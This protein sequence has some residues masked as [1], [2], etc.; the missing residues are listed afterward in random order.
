MS[1]D[2][3]APL[4]RS[5]ERLAARCD[6]AA[7]R[8]DLLRQAQQMLAGRPG[9]DR[10]ARLDLAAK[11]ERWRYRQLQQNGPSAADTAEELVNILDLTA[12]ELAGRPRRTARHAQAAVAGSACCAAADRAAECLDP[13]IGL[14]EL[15]D[16]A[17]ELTA[18]HFTDPTTGRRRVLLYAPLYLSSHCVNY[19]EYCGFRYPNGIERRHLS[20][21]EAVEQAELLRSRGLKSI[22]L[23]AGDFPA[24]TT[25]EYYVQVIDSVVRCGLEPAVEI[26]PQPTGVYES[27][28][29][30]G[31]CGV[32]L[33]QET[34][35]RRLYALYHPRGSKAEYDWRLE[36][37]ERA[38]E[39][40]ISRLGLGILL[41]LADPR[42]DLLALIRHAE[43]LRERFP[44]CDLAV[45][46]PRIHTAPPSFEVPYRVDDEMLIRLYCALRI[47]LPEAELVLSTRESA[48]LRN[49]L[50]RICI[51]QLSAGSSTVPGGYNALGT[52]R[53]GEQ[54]PVSDH[55]DPAVVAAWLEAAGL[56]VQRRRQLG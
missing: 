47:A 17:A 25:G 37:P 20:P 13:E 8:L 39:G 11:L 28:A 14:G 46:L 38:A 53:G 2:L 3:D 45:S 56:Q 32:T 15:T 12:R 33:Y 48:A 44:E 54:F 16:R 42:D 10:T 26:A 21:A 30:A 1:I 18:R 31:A 50:T 34:Y 23:V 41:G 19:C 55:R 22:L 27:L 4:S 40:G 35:D 6:H 7:H 5:I 24:L 49:R 36:G 29:A 9:A 51:T 43:Y 52:Y